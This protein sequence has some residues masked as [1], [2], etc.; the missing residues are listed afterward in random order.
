MKSPTIPEKQGLLV[1]SEP[2]RKLT[3]MLLNHGSNIIIIEIIITSVI[4]TSTAFV[5]NN[6]EK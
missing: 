2:L 5:R 6:N 4:I 1:S 3:I